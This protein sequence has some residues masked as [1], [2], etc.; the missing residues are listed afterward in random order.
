MTELSRAQIRD[1]MGQVLKNQ[2]KALP[3]DDAADLREVGF[4]S[5]DFSELALRVEDETGEELNFDA[6]GLRR[7]ATVGDVL[8]FLVELQQ[9]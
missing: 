6:P 9:R 4:R 2:G 8:D 1:L 7:I 5:L 3:D